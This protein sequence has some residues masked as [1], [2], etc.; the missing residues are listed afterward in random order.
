MSIEIIL[1]IIGTTVAIGGAVEAWHR[2]HAWDWLKGALKFKRKLFFSPGKVLSEIKKIHKNIV[3]SYFCPEI[4][5]G[6]GGGDFVGGAIVANFLA[7]PE[8]GFD[9]LPV[10][11]LELERDAEGTPRWNEVECKSRLEACAKYI[12]GKCR[13]RILLVDDIATGGDTIATVVE[14]LKS[15]SPD[16]EIRAVMIVAEPEAVKRFRSQ[17]Y[18]DEKLC[19]HIPKKYKKVIFPWRS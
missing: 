6:I 1:S 17:D 7:S 19:P 16:L 18:W 3:K 9:V 5:V 4:I 14:K 2:G 8:I 12:E 13:R 15:S 10:T 11:T